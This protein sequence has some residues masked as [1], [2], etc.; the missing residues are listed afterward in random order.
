LR[1]GL[2]SLIANLIQAPPY[3]LPADEAATLATWLGDGLVAHYAGDEVMPADAL[4]ES[5]ALLANPGFVEQLAGV[6][7]LS[8]WTDLAPL[9]NQVTIDLATR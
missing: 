3:S 5:Q 4:A 8:I 1:L 7:L 2:E 6:M 9:D